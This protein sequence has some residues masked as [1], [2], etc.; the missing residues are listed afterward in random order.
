M[1]LLKAVIPLVVLALGLMPETAPRGYEAG[2]NPSAGS[3]C[4]TGCRLFAIIMP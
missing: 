2:R 4:E 1:K 3:P